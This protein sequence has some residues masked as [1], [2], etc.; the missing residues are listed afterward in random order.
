MI[1]SRE[2][3]E[4]TQEILKRPFERKTFDDFY[5]QKMEDVYDEYSI[6]FENGKL[7]ELLYTFN[8]GGKR[9]RPAI[10]FASSEITEDK[11]LEDVLKYSVAVESAHTWSLIIDDINDDALKRRDG[12]THHQ[13]YGL[14]FSIVDVVDMINFVN[15]LTVDLPQDVR[16]EMFKTGVE[17]SEGQE[18]DILSTLS[19][20]FEIERKKLDELEFED[21]LRIVGGK[22]ASLLRASTKGPAIINQA[23]KEQIQALGEYGEFL[24]VS[25]QIKDDILDFEGGERLGK[26]RYMDLRSGK[27]SNLVILKTYNELEGNER[28]ELKEI[29]ENSEKDI[30]ALDYI[31]NLNGIPKARKTMD[32]YN[33]KAL[34]NLDIFEESLG[35]NYL[36]NLLE[37]N[38]ERK[39]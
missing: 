17:M 20:D 23:P 38:K 30:K 4:Q 31:E 16:E 2:V 34:E 32:E 1:S 13:K 3:L 18:M 36:I 14:D 10:C 37:F 24:G 29:L 9:I 21:Y 12:P 6:F 15:L 5:R 8:Q 28:K 7:D 11:K 26:E 33:E 27:L 39:I 22:S 35:K 25:Y 19:R